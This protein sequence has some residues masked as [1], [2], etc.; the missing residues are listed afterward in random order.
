MLKKQLTTNNKTDTSRSIMYN[1]VQK[2]EWNVM[3]F[4][5][6]LISQSAY[7]L[8]ILT[9]MALRTKQAKFFVA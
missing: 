7:F 4:F 2:T 9:Q 8:A 3:L 1:R 5:E 6:L